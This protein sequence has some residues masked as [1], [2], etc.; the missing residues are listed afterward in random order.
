VS[1]ATTVAFVAILAVVF[2]G[3][4]GMLV[5]QEARKRSFDEGPVY[6]V[7]DAVRYIEERLPEDVAG[8]LRRADVRR[9]VEWEVYYL[10]GLAQAHRRDPVETVAGGA[11][12]AIEYIAEQISTR[13][14]AAY[15]HDDIREVLRHEAGY[16]QSIG[17]V[18]GEVSEG[19][20]GP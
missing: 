4:V 18:G 1:G 17:A 5:W 11:E 3:V 2:L 19:G 15:A 16:L 9:I 8:R 12:P 10:Q 7:E 6:V 13:H 14:G 20:D